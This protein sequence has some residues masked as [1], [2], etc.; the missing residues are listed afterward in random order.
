MS[1]HHGSTL[2]TDHPEPL[3]E[4]LQGLMESGPGIPAG[5]TLELFLRATNRVRVSLPGSDSGEKMSRSSELGMAVRRFVQAEGKAGFATVNRCDSGHYLHALRGADQDMATVDPGLAPAGPSD[6]QT[7]SEPCLDLAEEPG[8]GE[9]DLSLWLSEAV[10][11]VEAAAGRITPIQVESGW[12]ESGRTSEALVNSA[13]LRSG[14]RRFRTWAA[15][16]VVSEAGG[17]LFHRPRLLVPDQAGGMPSLE[18]VLERLQ[19]FP[20]FH[21]ECTVEPGAPLVFLPEAA[22][23][24]L[25]AV[26][27][28]VHGA[29]SRIGEPV[30]RGW[31]LTDHPHQKGLPFGGKF[32]DTGRLTQVLQLADGR[33]SLVALGGEGHGWRPSFRDPPRRSFSNLVVESSGEPRP[34]RGFLV[35]ELRI[36]RLSGKRFLAVAHGN[37]LE[38]GVAV[39][40]GGRIRFAF[41]PFRIPAMIPGTCGQAR[42]TA[43]GIR[44]PELVLEPGDSILIE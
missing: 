44:T 3:L 1:P 38:D 14:R 7:G 19:A 6:V 18:P 15:L 11:Q 27:G 37:R 24:L 13:G 26:A 12:V 20:F 17:E 22:A 31:N 5:E 34:D 39:S 41:N 43:L 29:G 33:R 23:T 21:L 30:G 9:S 28:L 4:E 16:Q 8:Q 25:Q 36:L 35:S 2:S 42:N 32:D 40:D 10:E